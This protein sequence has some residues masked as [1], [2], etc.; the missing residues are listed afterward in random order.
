MNTVDI[1]GVTVLNIIVL[2]S[3]IFVNYTVQEKIVTEINK[4]NKQVMDRLDSI[5]LRYK[6]NAIDFKGKTI[7]EILEDIEL[8][9]EKQM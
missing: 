4:E 1:I 5:E 2:T 6:N 3:L 8:I 7:N 9:L